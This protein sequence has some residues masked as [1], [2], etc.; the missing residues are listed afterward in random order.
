MQ[1]HVQSDSFHGLTCAGAPVTYP[2]MY[3][4][5]LFIKLSDVPMFAEDIESCPNV[6]KRRNVQ[7]LSGM[8][9][10]CIPNLTSVLEI[11][12]NKTKLYQSGARI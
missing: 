9:N 2:G 5:R 4:F 12:H 1:C 11:Y 10:V 7:C 8:F 6:C 3:I